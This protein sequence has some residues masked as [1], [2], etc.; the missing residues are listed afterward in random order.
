MYMFISK[1]HTNNTKQFF[2]YKITHAV[3]LHLNP[4][5]LMQ[6]I[7]R[8]NCLTNMHSRSILKNCLNN[9][10]NTHTNVHIQYSPPPR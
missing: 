10:T 1:E 4:K 7:F 6:F 3:K 9:E 8:G 2:F 5:K